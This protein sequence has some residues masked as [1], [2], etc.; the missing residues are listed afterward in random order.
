M[1]AE[2]IYENIV[3]K[4]ELL[5]IAR[6]NREL[7]HK[8][9]RVQ[10]QKPMFRLPDQKATLPTSVLPGEGSKKEKIKPPTPMKQQ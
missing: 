10:L 7:A 4:K 5:P 6:I 2:Q 3:V 8:L 1:T 9:F